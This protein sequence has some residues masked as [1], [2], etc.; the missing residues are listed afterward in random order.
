MTLKQLLP[1]LMLMALFQ[2]G[3][4]NASE[5][6]TPEVWTPKKA[7]DFALRNS[8][9]SQIAAQRMIEAK[10][11]QSKSAASFYPTVNLSGN[12]G[13][14]NNPMYSFG[15]ILNQGAYVPGI[16]FN[17][18]GRTDNLN[19]TAAVQ[20]RFYN[21]GQDLARNQAAAAGVD[22]S[23]AERKAILLRLEFEAFRSFQKIEEAELILQ[24][25]EEG[26]TA[27]RSSL[28]VAQ[29]RYDAGDL[30]RTDLLNLEVEESRAVQNQI[31]ATHNLELSKKIFLQL[32]GLPSGEVIID[33]VG[34]QAPLRPE[35]LDSE[36]RPE[37]QRLLAATR[38]AEAELR[39][40][41]GGW[42][43]T[44]DG[45][46][47]Y[48]YDQGFVMDGGGDSWLAGIKVNFNLFDGGNSSADVALGKAKLS[49]L[50]AEKKKLELAINLEMVQSELALSEAEQSLVV[51]QKMVDLA[52]ESEAL[53]QVRFKEGGILAS[54]LINVEN[55]LTDA[56][57]RNATATS[58]L[59]IAIA[60]LRRASGL[61]QFNNIAQTPLPLESRQ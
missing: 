46:A 13:Q 52:T 22:V 39:A 41:R 54:D 51:T 36:L 44:V 25:G 49:S 20:Y 9:D 60:D 56:R 12:Y 59:R 19:L 4:C 1:L 58:A 37:M 3:L 28:Q 7:V 48:Q 10:A 27:I 15:N 43:P 5:E 21:G 33:T 53:S 57:V 23:V 30:L 26:V 32:L 31:R 61:S 17:N 34:T 18:P 14:T 50:R 35:R 11:L 55:S 47:A 42:L 24:A 8:P 45:F 16:D 40:A 29:A 2:G 6:G 38:A